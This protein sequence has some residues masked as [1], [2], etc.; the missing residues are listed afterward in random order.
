MADPDFAAQRR[1]LISHIA[2]R[3]PLDPRVL[4]ALG[5]V[6]RHEFLPPAQWPWAYADRALPGDC[7]KTVSQPLIVAL[8][9]DL[10]ALRGGE[11]V[12]E[13]G[14]G[15][16]Y[17]TAVLAELGCRI[18]SVERVAALSEAARLRLVR[19][20]Y[21]GIELRVGDGRTGW[22]E[23]AP[24]DRVL[25]TAAAPDLP[26]ALREQL[27]PGGRLVMPLGP[28]T[29]QQLMAG[30]KLPDGQLALRAVL[31]VLFLSLEG[32]GEEEEGEREGEGAKPCGS[33]PQQAR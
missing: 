19:L 24:F 18:Y 9:S 32:D 33:G 26:A 2:A 29:T 20:G 4:A 25:C 22:P 10:L 12:L 15:M 11:R 8:M 3:M 30:E 1:Q 31:P 16:G 14:T 5:A 6:P 17:Q 28:P 7:G 27:R 23:H 21:A 13:I